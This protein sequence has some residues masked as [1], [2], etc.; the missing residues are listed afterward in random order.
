MT[1]DLD[2]FGEIARLFRPLTLGAPEALGLADDAAVLRPP[3][4]TELVVTT[5]TLVAGVHF[6]AD[7]PHDL[8]ARKLLRVNLSDLAAKA[9]EPWGWFLN[10]AWSEEAGSADR[11]AFA[12]GLAQDQAAFGLRLFGGDTVRT[13]GPLTLSATLIGLAPVGDTVRRGGAR[14]GNAL[15]V[16]GPIGDAG[17]GLAALIGEAGAPEGEDARVLVARHRLP[18]PRL[19]L[20]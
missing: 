4:G 18:E 16:T 6:L 8:V 13:G 12:A 7:T 11:E 10:V 9:A 15:R 17:L 3:A 2:E 19:D 20:R 5:D 1:Q 14:A